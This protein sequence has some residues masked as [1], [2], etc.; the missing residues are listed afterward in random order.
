MLLDRSTFI[1]YKLVS[2][3]RA[4]M[5]NNSY[6]PVL[7]QGTVIISLNSQRLL[8]HKVLHLPVLWV[9]LYSLCAH[10]RQPRCGFLGSYKMEIYVYFPGVVLSID[11]STDCHLSYAPL[12]KSPP[13]PTL[14]YIH[15]QCAH[16]T[17]PT[18]C[19]ALCGNTGSATPPSLLVPAPPA[20]IKDNSSL[21]HPLALPSF[22]P[23][24]L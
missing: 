7:G 23:G 6:A 3:L 14:H 15:L 24:V 16:T 13:L 10:I 5:G 9:P 22:V 19:L 17:Y 1:S 4:S 2:N 20:I 18:E 21:S 12:S 11:T 8:I